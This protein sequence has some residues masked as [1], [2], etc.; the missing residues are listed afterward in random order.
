LPGVERQRAAEG[1]WFRHRAASAP[2]DPAPD[3]A[4]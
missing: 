3:A 2:V 4:C 1:L